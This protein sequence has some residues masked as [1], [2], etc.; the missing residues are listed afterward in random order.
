VVQIDYT[1]HIKDFWNTFPSPR[2]L[3]F[4]KTKLCLHDSILYHIHWTTTYNKILGYRYILYSKKNS[5]WQYFC[6]ML[7]HFHL[8][9]SKGFDMIFRIVFWSLNS[10]NITCIP[11]HELHISIGISYIWNYE[12]CNKVFL[13][14]F[15]L[16]VLSSFQL[17]FFL[18]GMK[19]NVY[20]NVIELILFCE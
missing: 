18:I 8:L 10:L 9:R 15:H 14:V 1:L 17:Y 16:N 2:F 4:F 11:F 20:S 5:L 6:I 7:V 12:K 3:F 19:R 13:W